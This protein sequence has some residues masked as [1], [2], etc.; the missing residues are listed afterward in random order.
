[1]KTILGASSSLLAMLLPLAGCNGDTEDVVGVSGEDREIVTVLN[2]ANV[3]AIAL[4]KLALERARTAPARAFA[5]AMA[6]EHSAVQEQLVAQGIAPGASPVSQELA[7]GS[8]EALSA[9]DA[10]RAAEFD[11]VYLESQV[12]LHERV[13]DLLDE[14]LSPAANSVG[15][16]EELQTTMTAEVG[17]LQQAY[18]LLDDLVSHADANPSLDNGSGGTS[19]IGSAT[20]T[21]GP[22]GPDFPT[23]GDGAGGTSGIGSTTGMVPS[24]WRGSY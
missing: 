24:D 12:E 19:G 21:A 10:A 8:Q 16:Q 22:S 9:L 13:L 18:S 15:L 4:S 7:R 17:H 1:M 23:G 11:R 5:H 14:R 3:G 20:G 6:T 2:A